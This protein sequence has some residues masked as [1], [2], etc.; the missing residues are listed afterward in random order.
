MF[1]K[2]QHLRQGFRLYSFDDRQCCSFLF[3]PVAGLVDESS[4]SICLAVKVVAPVRDTVVV[5]NYLKNM[6]VVA[7]VSS[8]FAE[9]SVN[10]FAEAVSSFAEVANKTVPVTLALEDSWVFEQ[11]LQFSKP[12]KM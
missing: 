12:Y 11:Q 5:V 1:Y 10:R 4:P 3:G 6:L 7:V 2:A 9:V 8:S